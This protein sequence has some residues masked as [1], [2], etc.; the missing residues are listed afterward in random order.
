VR[1]LSAADVLVDRLHRFVST[2]AA[3]AALQA[4]ALLA[5][6]EPDGE[7]LQRRVELERLSGA[8]EAITG[9]RREGEKR[10]RDPEKAELLRDAGT[11]ERLIGPVRSP[12]SKLR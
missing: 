9:S 6:E 11:P 7:H 10:P 3:D 8:L 4:I 2:G 1:V 5:V 12:Q